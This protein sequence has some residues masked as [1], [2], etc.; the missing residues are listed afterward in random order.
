MMAAGYQAGQVRCLPALRRQPPRSSGGMRL[1][2]L[3]RDDQRRPEGQ[4]MP[5]P[6]LI[7]DY[8]TALSAQLPEPIVEELA[9]GLDQTRQHYLTRGLDPD[10]ATDAALAEFGAPRVI[11][12]AFIRLSPARRA[13]RRLLAAG[14]VVGACWGTALI[15]SRAWTWPVPDLSRLLFGVR[16]P[17]PAC[18]P[19]SSRRLCG[20]YR[21]RR[22]TAYLRH[23]RPSGRHLADDRGR[24]GQHGPPRVHRTGSAPGS[25]RLRSRLPQAM[26]GAREGRNRLAQSA[27][28]QLPH[29]LAPERVE[30]SAPPFHDEPAKA[31]AAG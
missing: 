5:E 31:D 23:A 3:R 22:R 17:V 19:R 25:E 29:E 6:S 13:A 2:G 8:L 26:S 12:A 27:G 14:P 28:A 30:G 7:R 24:G 16:K 4:A 18:Q 20:H 10:A 15:S 1:A 9:D 21:A 11:V